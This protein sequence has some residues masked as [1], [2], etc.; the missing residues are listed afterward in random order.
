MI[1][2]GVAVCLAVL[3]AAGFYST[4]KVRGKTGNFLLAGRS[5]SAPV[6]A[7]ILMSQ[8]V[9]SNA[10]LGSA[11]LAAS[12]GF[13]AGAAMP[14]GIALSV[15]LVGLF[16]ARK[17]RATEIV[18][19]PEFFARRFG[20]GTEVTASVLT[21]ASFG[22]L[23]AGN[24]VALGFLLEYFIGISYSWAVLALIPFVL[25]YTMAGGM[26]ASVYT[27]IV[28]FGILTVGS[29]SLAFWVG[30]GPGFSAPEGLG[31][32]G[33]GQLTSAAEGAAINWATI[34]A[35][36]L[37]NLVAIDLMQRVFSARSPETAQRAC[38]SAAAGILVLCVPLSLVAL[39]A[40]TIVGEDAAHGPILYVLLGEYAPAWL[41][42]T[43]ISGLVIASLTT[44]SG[45][46]LSTATVLVRNVLRV[47][48][49]HAEMSADVM[50]A[51][52]LAMLPMAALGAIVALR[53][54]QTGIL[55]TLTFDLLL[56][57]IVVPF[58][59]GLYWKRG[60][61]RAVAAA[62][63]TGITVR[64]GFFVLTPTI[65]GV[66]NTLLYFPNDLVGAE[67]DGWTTFL[68]AGVSLAAYVLVATFAAPRTPTLP[69]APAP[70]APV[71]E[72]R[73]APAPAGVA[74]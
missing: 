13:W 27:G 55:L 56:A 8:V 25:A 31:I 34:L 57:S 29:I 44:V 24:L 64:V 40:V 22:I 33:M 5:L 26:F 70:V 62:V 50:K 12:F 63:V 9:D 48:G 53:V 17:L 52:R 20:R 36:G 3:L 71:A 4:R 6:V 42:I 18:T 1:I 35:L 21:V 37:G 23:L 61:A 15:L 54:P 43:V 65:Y 49:E 58:I 7:V 10:T 69:Q 28:Q 74:G 51:T 39:A 66:D 19:L 11:D 2:T 68:A 67:V 14:I 47:G 60:D 72:P 38:F 45:I 41:G 30:F 46:L 59:L 73:Q 16:F 32:G